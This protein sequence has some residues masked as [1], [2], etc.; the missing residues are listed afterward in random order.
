MANNLKFKKMEKKIIG[1]VIKDEVIFQG[2]KVEEFGR[3]I[4][5]ERENCYKIFKRTNMSILQLK[6]ISKALNHNFFEDI[7]NNNIE[8]EN[9]EVM[10][11]FYNRRAVSQFHEIVPEVLEE[12]GREPIISFGRPSGLEKG[13]KIPDFTL[14]DYFITFTVGET[15]ME[16]S[17]E[18][19][20]KSFISYDVKNK[21]NIEIEVLHNEW[22]KQN[23]PLSNPV[24]INIKLD[25][26]TKEE[27]IKTLKFAFEIYDYCKRINRI[28][29]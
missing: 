29:L 24:Q 3:R 16:R 22:V 19:C 28:R 7:I 21:D 15:F 13:I 26:K 12:L 6:E 2:L 8:M 25:Y 20:K 17:P 27:W 5:C 18:H 14:T 23:M 10:K 11:D 1:E 9:P 4:N